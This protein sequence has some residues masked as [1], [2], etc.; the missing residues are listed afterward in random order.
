MKEFL[1]GNWFVLLLGVLFLAGIIYLAITKQWVKLRGLAY[2]LMLQAERIFSSGEGKQKFDAVFEKLYFDLIPA[3][4]RLFVSP[5]SIREKLQEWYILAKDY[6][7]N[8]I[9]DNSQN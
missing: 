5:R 2:A 7:D 3:W 4:L 6:L 8:G 1:A 9:V